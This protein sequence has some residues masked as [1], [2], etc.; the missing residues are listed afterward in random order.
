M[1]FPA[2]LPLA[3]TLP[4][5]GACAPLSAM[6]ADRNAN[7]AAP[8]R[9]GPLTVGQTWTVSGL[10]DGRAV[11]ST[12]NIRDLVNV[13]NGSGSVNARDQITAFEESRPGFSVA[14]FMPDTRVARFRW[15]GESDGVSYTCRVTNAA[16]SPLR[17]VLTYERSGKVIANGTCEALTSQTP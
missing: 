4:L 16:A 5:L 13:P 17:G 9:V 15:V 1:R 2:L 3:L 14:D 8:R 11:T 10:V 12:V 6:L 7:G